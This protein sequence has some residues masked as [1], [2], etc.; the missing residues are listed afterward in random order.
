MP[1]LRYCIVADDV[2]LEIQNKAS[3]IGF[4]GIAPNVNISVA[5]PDRPIARMAFL[6]GSGSSVPVG[7]Y[8]TR[9]QIL[10]P[11]GTNLLDDTQEPIVSEVTTPTGINAVVYCVPLPL[12]GF[13]TYRLVAI[14]NDQ[15]DFESEIMI[16]PAT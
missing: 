8:R 3:I 10:N 14:V 13:G 12:S 16:S 5:Y 15:P 2:R 11:Q 4:Y 9:L 7:S 1:I 6:L